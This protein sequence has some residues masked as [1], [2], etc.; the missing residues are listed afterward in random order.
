[1]KLLFD[2]NAALSIGN[3]TES[4]YITKLVSDPMNEC[5]LSVVVLWEIAIKSSLGKIDL[6]I[7]LV[8][9]ADA[10]A[11]RGYPILTVQPKHIYALET[12]PLIHK[13]PFDRLLVAQAQREDMVL[14]TTDSLLSEYGSNIKQV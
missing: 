6:G 3:G 11:D 9:F 8:E 1:M 7:S 13:D 4:S 14:L 12:L 5:F 2:T 10:F